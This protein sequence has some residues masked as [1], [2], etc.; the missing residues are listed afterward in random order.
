MH[1]KKCRYLRVFQKIEEVLCEQNPVNSSVL[2]TSKDKSCGIYAGSCHLT[3]QNVVNY[4]AL[5]AVYVQFLN[6]RCFHM[7]LVFFNKKRRYRL[8]LGDGVARNK[9]GGRGREDSTQDSMMMNAGEEFLHRCVYTQKLLR[10]EELLHTQGL[11]H[12][13]TFTQSGSSTQKFLHT[14]VFTQRNL[15]TDGFYTQKLLD[16]EKSLHR[17]VLTHRN[18]YTEKSL[19]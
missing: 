13:E 9:A 17:G 6:E 5:C 14:G 3:S 16:R 10:T 1:A 4:S 19:Y 12:R 11:L 8:K 15:Y 7:F 18:F 2:S